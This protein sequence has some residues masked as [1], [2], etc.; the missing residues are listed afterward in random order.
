VFNAFFAGRTLKQFLANEDP[1]SSEAQA[2]LKKLQDAGTDALPRYLQ[3]ISDSP[4]AH[5]RALR[6]LCSQMLDRTSAMSLM[7]ELENETTDIRNAAKS[8]LTDSQILS[9]HQILKQ[10]DEPNSAK[11]EI[12]DLIEIQQ[13]VH[14]P[15]KLFLKAL[16]LKHAYA[17]QL[18]GIALKQKDRIDLKGLSLDPDSI[19]K[20]ELRIEV[21]RF[22][23]QLA[24][25]GANELLL[26]FLQDNF[27]TV[28]VEALKG[29]RNSTSA[30]DASPIAA[31]LPGYNTMEQ[32]MALTVLDEKADARV[33]PS[34][35]KLLNGNEPELRNVA[36]RII[37]QRAEPQ[38]LRQLLQD[39]VETPWWERE[40]AEKALLASK[41]TRLGRA[42]AKLSQDDNEKVRDLA[43]KLALASGDAGS[44]EDLKKRALSSEWE[45]REKAIL[46]LAGSHDTGVVSLMADVI[47]KYPNSSV[48]ALRALGLIGHLKGIEIA[49]KAMQVKEAQ[50]QR[51]ALLTIQKLV[52]EKYA[53]QIRDLILKR[54]SRLQ[55]TVRDTAEQVVTDLTERF[56]LPELHINTSE[57][58]NTSLVDAGEYMGDKAADASVP[59]APRPE[60][61]KVSIDSLQPGDMW[62][63][64]YRVG[65]EMGRGAMGRVLLADDVMV[66]EQIILKFMLP[67]LTSDADARERFIREL[68]YARKVSHPNV[69]RIHDFI[70][71]DEVAAISMEY[72]KSHSVDDS[73]KAGVRYELSETI[74]ILRQIAL[75]M[76][77]AHA[78]L[79]IHRDLK[80]SNILINDDGFVKV[81]DFGIAAASSENEA[82]LTK[83]GKVIGTPAYLSPERVKGL[84]ADHRSDIYA[85]GIIAH[86]MLTGE[87]PYKGEPMSMLFQHVEGKATPVH[88]INNEVPPKISLFVKKLMAVNIDDRAQSMLDVVELL[89]K[90]ALK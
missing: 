33:L 80:P 53:G 2:L 64:R 48:S 18:L 45:T 61:V 67:E 56:G 79:V 59:K 23:A 55:A 43:A 10:L 57:V 46:D 75:G 37:E 20:P 58:F 73:L 50:V 17:Q 82:N 49:A 4:P 68:R 77:A 87:L 12:I 71:I 72:F 78:Q 19:S 89:D 39:F 47:E 40:H 31:A 36:I 16:Q 13:G 84:K 51:E 35:I 29:L 52:N 63:E 25:P 14:P 38:Q 42:A 22:L 9:P 88:E 81:V 83:T 65:K 66:N 76:A 32:Q 6:E 90:L 11:Q 1:N 34:L 54:V 28:V 44:L 21:V 70:Y 15:E 3:A 41:S 86:Y 30:F 69:I 60:P 74:S 27:K 62:A 8:I 7:S 26:L 5:A 85:L 24:K